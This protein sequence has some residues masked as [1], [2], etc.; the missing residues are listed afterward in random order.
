MG[1]LLLFLLLWSLVAFDYR[2]TRP[3]DWIQHAVVFHC[4]GSRAIAFLQRMACYVE[5]I[6]GYLGCFVG[7]H[8]RSVRHGL[9]RYP[10]CLSNVSHT[11]S[12][13]SVADEIVPISLV[14]CL[15]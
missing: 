4:Q 3:L 7:H 2:S 13:M 9:P 10:L 1:Y 5:A 14:F 15:S 11:T 12:V 6:L 8:R